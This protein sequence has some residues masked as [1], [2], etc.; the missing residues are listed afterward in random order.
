MPKLRNLLIAA[1]AAMLSTSA[2]LAE[3]AADDQSYLP[4]QSLRSQTKEFD[5]LAGSR[6]ERSSPGTH[7]GM[8]HSYTHRHYAHW[9]G[10]RQY[11][12]RGLPFFP[13]IFTVLFR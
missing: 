3:T 9:R 2:A 1:A 10:H 6:A 7:Y 8:R 12:S 5:T 11:A 13:G 4:P